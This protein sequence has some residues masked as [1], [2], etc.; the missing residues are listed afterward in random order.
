L[1][2]VQ[3]RE[4]WRHP[5]KSLQGEQL[6]EATVDA[7]GLVGDR[8]WGIRDEATGNILT[9]RREPLLLLAS[10]RR[11]D[12]GDP[13]ITLPD[14]DSITGAG[15]ATDE[16]LSTWLGRRV[17]LVSALEEGP[18]QAEYFEDATDDTS[19]ALTFT[20][21]TGH[22][23]DT[24]PLLLLTTASLR[25]GQEVH[26]AGEWDVRRFRPNLLV[27]VEGTGW[28]ED[29]WCGQRVRVGED[30]ELEP[31]APCERCSMVTRPQPGLGRD[32]DV[33]RALAREHG[34]TF[35]VWSSVAI[36]GQVRVGDTV[37]VG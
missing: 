22:L 2:S 9:G 36:S 35:G 24:L 27:E 31:K 30:V 16:A 5:V 11:T 20:M 8:E 37:A 29:G 28:V 12:E 33:F 4:L 34:A 15:E 1:G 10:A 23:V 7:D 18:R 25:R 6:A 32:L 13:A 19:Q 26:A 17:R 14:G 21:P 3:V